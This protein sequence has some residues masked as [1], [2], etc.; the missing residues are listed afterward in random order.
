M[1]YRVEI[2]GKADAQFSGLDTVSRIM[3]LS[4]AFMR[5]V[6]NCRASGSFRK[7]LFGYAAIAY[8]SIRVT[9]PNDQAHA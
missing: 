3:R 1:S 6:T 5:D 9:W 8:R 4:L 7:P 2:G